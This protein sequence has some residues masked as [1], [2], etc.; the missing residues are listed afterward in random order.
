MK[1]SKTALLLAALLAAPALE[2]HEFWIEPEA[3]RIA[4]GEALV[5][6][7]LVGEKLDG[8]TYSFVPPNF[9]RF[10]ILLG[11]RAIEVEGRAGDKPALNMAV[12]GEGL[13]TVVHVTRE[14]KLTYDSWEKFVTFCTHKDFAWAL[15]RHTERGLSQEKVRERYT[16]FA[17]SLIA[18]GDGAGSDRE[19]GLLTEIVA[20][21]NP[22]TDDLSEGF[23]VQ[24]LFEGAPRAD[25]QVEVFSRAPDGT[26]SVQTYRTDAEGRAMVEATPGHFLLIDS[27]VMRELPV[28][29]ETDP[30]WESLWASLTFRVPE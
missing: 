18:L 30:A 11:D 10:E 24:V 9:T 16:R 29:A 14:Y 27:V 25:T 20:L 19:A 17:K 3:A 4:P 26:V 21:A 12:E 28:E 8:A 6:D 5:A 7:L 13:A 15:E 23:P 1:L 22:F 2:A